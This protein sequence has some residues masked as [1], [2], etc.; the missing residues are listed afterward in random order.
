[1]IGSLSR[2]HPHYASALY[3]VFVQPWERWNPDKRKGWAKEGIKWLAEEYPGRLPEYLPK[4]MPEPEPPKVAK[5]RWV[6]EMLEQGFS[7]RRICRDV[8]CSARLVGEVADGM[9]GKVEA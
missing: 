8:G 1:L 3:W 9:E 7:V 5:R 4:G 6:G 2:I